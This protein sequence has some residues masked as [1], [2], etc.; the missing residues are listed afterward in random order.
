MIDVSKHLTNI[1]DY[2]PEDKEIDVEPGVIQDNLNN[3]VKSDGLRFAPD[4]STSNR[5]MIGNN[6]CGSYSV[7]Y[8]TTREHVKSVDVIVADG[9]EATFDALSAHELQTK[10]DL[11]TFEG[12]LYRT[13]FNLLERHGQQILEHFS[14]PS[15]KRRNT[16]YALDE[17]YRHH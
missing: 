7:Y 3:Y 8:G 17:L 16:G 4:T 15:I 1:L 10:L 12:N 14:H 6:S 11:Q 13:V 9:S 2:R 5:A